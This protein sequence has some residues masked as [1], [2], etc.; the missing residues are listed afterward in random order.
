V[1]R[2]RSFAPQAVRDVEDAAD[3]LADG[4]GGVP[5]ARKFLVGVVDAA[6]LV[7]RRPCSVIDGP[8]SCRIHTA[9]SGSRDFHI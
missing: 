2:L 3:W 4:P 5:L 9:S 8:N 6:D 7:A 1:T